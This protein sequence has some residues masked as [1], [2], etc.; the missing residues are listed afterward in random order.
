MDILSKHFSEML[1]CVGILATLFFCFVVFLLRAIAALRQKLRV[2]SSELE[3]ANRRLVD[4]TENV[5]GLASAASQA[6]KSTSRFLANMSHEIRTPLNAIVGFSNVLKNGTRDVTQQKYCDVIISSGRLLLSTVNDILDYSKIE[7]GNV[8]VESVA[9]DLRRLASEAI[10][11]VALKVNPEKVRVGLTIAPDV[12]V[13][14][15]VDPVRLKQVLVNVLS[16]AVKFTHEGSIALSVAIEHRDA[17]A[18]FLRCTVKD[19]GLGISQ[20]R[21]GMTLED[22]EQAAAPGIR[23]LGGTSLSFAISRSL[24]ALMGGSLD[25]RSENGQGA[26]FVFFVPVGGGALPA[27]TVVCGGT[28]NTAEA[29]AGLKGLRVLV[30][31][32][33]ETNGQLLSVIL[34]SWGVMVELVHNGKDALDILRRGNHDLCLM[35]VQMPRM[36]G[37]E[38]ARILRGEG[39]RIPIVAL[40]ASTSAE[41]VD[42]CRA[43]GMDA[44]VPKPIDEYDLATAMRQAMKR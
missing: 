31:E 23:T 35:D 28:R 30:A 32:D 5:C 11:L 20:E 2:T 13:V 8:V 33:V 9:V 12:P 39:V 22:F 24:V 17:G 7:A 27:D 43:A 6:N 10:S 41:S 3:S 21:L 18:V 40:T 4:A 36:S 37:I 19:T 34:G 29:V 38:A 16:S 44:F 42:V 26:E 14:V 15:F 1:F 25:V